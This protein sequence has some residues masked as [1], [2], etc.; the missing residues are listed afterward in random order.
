MCAGD[1]AGRREDVGRRQRDRANRSR[2]ASGSIARAS[3]L[4]RS[5]AGRSRFAIGC[6]C[7]AAASLANSTTSTV[8]LRYWV[9]STSTSSPKATIWR[10]IK[11][12]ARILSIHEGVEGI[13]FAVW[14][15]NAQAVSV[16]GDFNAWDGR[17]MAMRRRGSS[18][19]WELF[20]PGS[21][22]RS[23]L[24]IPNTRAGRAAPAAKGGSSSRASREA[25]GDGVCR[26]RPVAPC[27]ARR[28]L[29]GG[30]LA[31]Q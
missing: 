14:A 10:A 2:R 12:S 17:R 16:V 24:Q 15:P 23:P 7:R 9:S 19:Y 13:A 5:P 8:S 21:T 6:R 20:V 28:R 11:N 26:R 3:S 18:G 22:A 29:D 1:I 4:P 27:L 25:A 30:A 31:P